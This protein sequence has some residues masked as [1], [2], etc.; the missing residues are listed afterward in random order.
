[1]IK[2]DYKE[3]TNDNGTFHDS[4]DERKGIYEES[5][6]FALNIKHKFKSWEKQYSKDC[7]NNSYSV[8]IK[9]R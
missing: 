2:D 5:V 7:I 3:K 1:M 4:M 6:S 9:I 8:L